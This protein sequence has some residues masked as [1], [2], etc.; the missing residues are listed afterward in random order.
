MNL[1]IFKKDEYIL[2]DIYEKFEKLV[3]ICED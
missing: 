3:E 2:E 1:A